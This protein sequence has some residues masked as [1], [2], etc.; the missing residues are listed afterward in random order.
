MTTFVN[1]A[2]YGRRHNVTRED[3]TQI[4]KPA[5]TFPSPNFK[6]N[7]RYLAYGSN[8]SAETFLGRR[9]IKPLSQVA[10]R[11]PSLT[12]TFDLAGVP[13]KEPRF[14]N[15]R[16]RRDNDQELV[17][18]VYEVTPKDYT[19]ILMTEGGYS[20]IDVACTPLTPVEGID[21][22]LSKT[23]IVPTRGTRT[24]HDG[25]PSLRYLTLIMHGAKEHELPQ[26][27]QD[28]IASTGYYEA[29]TWRQ[30]LGTVLVAASLIPLVVFLF[31]LRNIL[32]GK[33]GRAPAWLTRMQQYCFK[34]IW[35]TYD[36]IW[37]PLYGDGESDRHEVDRVSLLRLGDATSGSEKDTLL[38]EVEEAA[39]SDF[40]RDSDPQDYEPPDPSVSERHRARMFSTS[41]PQRGEAVPSSNTLDHLA[42]ELGAMRL[43]SEHACDRTPEHSTSR[44]DTPSNDDNS[45]SSDLREVHY[46]S[47]TPYDADELKFRRARLQKLAAQAMQEDETPRAMEEMSA[48]IHTDRNAVE[49]PYKR[50]PPE[51]REKMRKMAMELMD[52]PKDPYAVSIEASLFER[53][54]P[55]ITGG[56]VR[57][58][59]ISGQ[60]EAYHE[61]IIDSPHMVFDTGAHSTFISADLLTPT[62]LKHLVGDDTDKA[63]SRP[64]NVFVGCEVELQGSNASVKIE[65]IA[66]VVP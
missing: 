20:V 38:V 1:R 12:L 57:L 3:A 30:K 41:S 21:S 36:A 61:E 22:F 35:M 6:E 49:F 52:N 63:H 23:L 53:Y 24:R 39:A 44:N 43:R 64:A 50:M 33:D 40:T 55:A 15:V 42:S 25:L 59:T 54:L 66:R 8:L 65:G 56:K 11:V 29:S 58:T 28:Y 47:N 31:A 10:V 7:I 5:T 34:A 9:G 26:D 51:W 19:T 37:K 13:Y 48:A 4:A 32:T 46:E 45:Q 62:F 60:D 27:Y 2:L 16:P 17:G 18:V 14:A